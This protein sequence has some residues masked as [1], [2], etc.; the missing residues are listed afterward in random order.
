MAYKRKNYLKRVIEI[1]KITLDKMDLGYT[2][3]EIYYQFI[4]NQFLISIKTF[5]N[6]LR[7]N[8]KKE[9][10]ELEQNI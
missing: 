9:L 1:Q 2:Q 5:G 7:V 6:Y 3:K 4:E 8:A 10:K